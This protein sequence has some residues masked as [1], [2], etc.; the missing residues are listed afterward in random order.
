MRSINKYVEE[1]SVF[2]KQVATELGAP[3]DTD[4][5]LRVTTAFF[6]TLRERISPG[7]SLHVI[8]QLPMILKGIYVDGWKLSETTSNARTLHEFLDEVRAHTNRTAARDF[9]DDMQAR[10]QLTAVIR[11]MR[12][13]VDD[14]EIRNIKVQLPEPIAELFEH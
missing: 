6:H 9:G 14:G 12:K 5:A 7:E 8:S 1:A 13:Y 11:V 3:E 10:D 2:F 4:H